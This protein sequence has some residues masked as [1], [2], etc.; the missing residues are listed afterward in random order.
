MCLFDEILVEFLDQTKIA[1]FLGVLLQ[2][3]RAWSIED[4][5]LLGIFS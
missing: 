5:G 3:L 1:W 4:F 2:K